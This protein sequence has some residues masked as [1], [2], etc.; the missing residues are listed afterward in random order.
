MA[1]D[2]DGLNHTRF[3]EAAYLAQCEVVLR[4][5]VKMMRF[6]LER[7][8]E[9]LFFCLFD[10]PDRLQHMFWRFREPNH[11]ANHDGEDIAV[12]RRVVED[13]YRTCDLIVGQA[14]QHVDDETLF[15]VLSDHGMNSFQRGI[16]L[17]SWLYYN[18]FLTLKNGGKPGE[19]AGEFFRDV[20]WSQTKAYALGL[21]GIYLN[22]R[23]REG[24]GIVTPDAAHTIKADI[25]KGL[26]GLRD[27]ERGEVAI[28]SVMAREA[29]YSGPYVGES[30]DLLVNFA[31]GYR[32]SWSTPLGGTP[33]GLFENNTKK[34]GGD[35]MIDPS[36][37]PGVFL[38]NR[39]FQGT[40]ASL[41]DLAPTILATLGVPA[42][43]S[44]EGSSLV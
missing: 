29:I 41:V 17:N 24:K 18:G 37:A 7:F 19:D 44:M 31:R 14:M 27:D 43:P 20:D 13:H 35:H 33:E 1:E 25:A 2:H 36:L 22:L 21:G 26:T 10:T 16:H 38:M 12:F 3:N 15:I 23:G 4:E 42:A 39:P 6:E 30:P 11:P 40:N 28:R 34:W 8:K 32:V 5:R 9:G